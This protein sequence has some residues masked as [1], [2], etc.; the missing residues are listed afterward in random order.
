MLTLA[1]IYGEINTLPLSLDPITSGKNTFGWFI[2]DILITLV[3]M[4][5]VENCITVMTHTILGW[6]RYF[7]LVWC[8]NPQVETIHSPFH[9]QLQLNLSKLMSSVLNTIS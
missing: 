6:L 1:C 4:N 7:R 2:L 8:P 9:K 5:R 3:W